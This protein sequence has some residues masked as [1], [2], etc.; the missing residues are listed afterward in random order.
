[1][2]ERHRLCQC[3]TMPHIDWQASEDVGVGPLSRREGCYGNPLNDE[4]LSEY[5]YGRSHQL[6][7][8]FQR[9]DLFRAHCYCWH[10]GS[11]RSSDS[12][13]QISPVERH[14]LHRIRGSGVRPVGARTERTEAARSSNHR[15]TVSCRAQ[16][17]G[18]RSSGR[19]EVEYVW[20]NETLRRIATLQH[21][22]GHA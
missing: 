1:M 11:W 20:S 12:W 5:S 22:W 21:R 2:V 10:V 15:P 17:I 6:Q 8:C 3:A 4:W 13:Q 14:R 19:D 9:T 16:P 18:E 7:W